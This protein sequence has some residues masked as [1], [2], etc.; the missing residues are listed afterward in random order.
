MIK[1]CYG[2]HN[3]TRALILLRVSINNMSLRVDYDTT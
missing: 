2:A 1:I 3:Q